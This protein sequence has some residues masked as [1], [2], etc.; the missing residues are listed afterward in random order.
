M[1]RLTWSF[2]LSGHLRSHLDGSVVIFWL[3]VAEVVRRWL[4]VFLRVEWE[5]V[6]KDQGI[7]LSAVSSEEYDGEEFELT[8]QETGISPR[9]SIN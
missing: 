2:E 5:L 6:R 4:W 9:Q 8:Y 3:E 1:L 7:A